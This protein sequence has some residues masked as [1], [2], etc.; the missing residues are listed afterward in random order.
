MRV[1]FDC[2]EEP[3]AQ[4]DRVELKPL[5]GW[6]LRSRVRVL[7]LHE[8][9]LVIERGNATTFASWNAVQFLVS[10]IWDRVSQETGTVEASVSSFHFTLVNGETIKLP[11][12]L[13][14]AHGARLAAVIVEKAGLEWVHFGSQQI[15][16]MPMLP[17][18]VTPAFAANLR[19]SER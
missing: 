15:A 16:G 3:G 9:G 17:M 18:A 11:A 8:H 7:A 10:G 6:L 1:R 12:A 2:V 4:I 14:L 13:A 19:L 5:F